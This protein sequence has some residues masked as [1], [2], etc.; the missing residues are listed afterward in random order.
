MERNRRVAKAYARAPA[1]SVNGS[2]AGFDGYSI[3]ING[4]EP[5]SNDPEAAAVKKM[6]G[7]VINK[8]M[9]QQKSFSSSSSLQM[10]TFFTPFP[11]ISFLNCTSLNKYHLM[12]DGDDHP[13]HAPLTIA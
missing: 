4:F 11:S 9:Q 12:F 13:S 8:Q 10:F 5:G 6:I 2:E 7:K 3:G 1:I